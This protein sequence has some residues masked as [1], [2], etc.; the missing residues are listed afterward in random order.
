MTKHL[1]SIAGGL[2]GML[3]ALMLWHVYSDHVLLH[4]VVDA[5]NGAAARQV[6]SAP[7]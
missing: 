1:A 4:Q 6:Q 3:L 7:K 5:I 2:V